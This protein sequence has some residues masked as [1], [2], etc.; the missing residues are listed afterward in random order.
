MFEGQVSEDEEGFGCV[1]EM[2]LGGSNEK[3][4]A[5]WLHAE[6]GAASW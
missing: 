5:K 3:Y 4:V 6:T 1:N 2:I